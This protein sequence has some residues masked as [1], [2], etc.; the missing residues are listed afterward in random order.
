MI[1]TFQEKPPEFRKSD[2]LKFEAAEDEEEESDT[3]SADAT[4][5]DVATTFSTTTLRGGIPGKDHQ[6]LVS[7]KSEN[8]L[9][10]LKKPLKMCE[11]ML[12]I[13]NRRRSKFVRQK[14][15]EIDSDSTDIDASLTPRYNS[16]R[17]LMYSPVNVISRL[18]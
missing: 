10:L 14:S 1:D 5:N 9:V 3:T 2:N 17:R 13:G 7:S 11:N 12:D 8:S 18:M 15:F 16:E 4:K 6:H